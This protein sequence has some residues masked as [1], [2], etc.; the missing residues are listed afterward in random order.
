MVLEVDKAGI[1][2]DQLIKMIPIA[3]NILVLISYKSWERAVT[4]SQR[5]HIKG[6]GV[7]NNIIIIIIITRP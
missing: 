7:N 3:I 4:L 5:T 1:L 6:K 2:G